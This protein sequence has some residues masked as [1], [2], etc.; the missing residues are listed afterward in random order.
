MPITEVLKTTEKAISKE[1]P[2]I[3]KI[4]PAEFPKEK[5]IDLNSSSNDKIPFLKALQETLLIKSFLGAKKLIEHLP[6]SSVQ[7]IAEI[8]KS[9]AKKGIAVRFD[10]D[11]ELAKTVEKAYKK[12]EDAGFDVPKCILYSKLPNLDI[13]ETYPCSKNVMPK[14]P[15]MLSDKYLEIQKKEMQNT[16]K[17][18]GKYEYL[19]TNEI[20]G[21]ICHEIGHWLHFQIRPDEETCKKIWKTVDENKICEEVS[22]YAFAAKNNEDGKEFVAE[23]CAGLLNGKT[24]SDYIMNIYKQLNGPMP[25]NIKKLKTVG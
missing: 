12:A 20:D 22:Y 13:A 3:R 15:I 16:K 4:V 17:I 11:L 6:F 23:V 2:N 5:F 14:V 1:V 7:E 24:Y 10:K 19:S 8:E 21:P 25:K 18:F 9:F